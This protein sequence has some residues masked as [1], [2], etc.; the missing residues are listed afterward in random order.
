MMAVDMSDDE[1]AKSH[2]RHING[3]KQD[4]PNERLFRFGT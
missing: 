4:V 3:G 2:L 1:L